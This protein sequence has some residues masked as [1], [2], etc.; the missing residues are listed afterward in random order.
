MRQTHREDSRA[1]Y[2]QGTLACFCIAAKARPPL[3]PSLRGAGASGWL[4]PGPACVARCEAPARG[5][6]VEG[7]RGGA[8]V[9]G[10]PPR[11]RRR[12]QGPH[13][14]P[15]SGVHPVGK[16]DCCVPRHLVHKG[17]PV[18]PP[19]CAVPPPPGAQA[20]RPGRAPWVARGAAA[21]TG[22]GMARGGAHVLA[23]RAIPRR[24]RVPCP[25]YPAPA[26]RGLHKMLCLRVWPS[27]C[28][29]TSMLMRRA[30]RR[31]CYAMQ[32]VSTQPCATM[33]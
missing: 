2:V 20:L 4:V 12:V 19:R 29:H 8:G 18:T 10:H 27:D 22:G 31:P 5:V 13:H 6:A 23:A 3:S 26:L 24:L 7:A 14:G 30:Q 1:A 21:G 28:H 33:G 9:R 15:H 16:F 17:P 25:W 11:H 32:G